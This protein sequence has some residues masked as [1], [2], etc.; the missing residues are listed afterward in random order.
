VD[1][2]QLFTEEMLP[3]L[4]ERVR[5]EAV[6][7]LK[8]TLALAEIA[9]Q[10]SIQVEAQELDERVQAIQE[11]YRDRQVDPDRLREVV[12]EELLHE[13]VIAW[14]REHSQIEFVTED[15]KQ[16]A[17][18]EEDAA[19]G[20]TESEATVAAADAVQESAPEPEAGDE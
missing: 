11:Q 20:E 16:A 8:R 2:K 18:A 19:P 3:T 1:I 12:E 9:K 17:L 13:K 14:L 4:R 5:P 15:A 7:R 6:A 10:E